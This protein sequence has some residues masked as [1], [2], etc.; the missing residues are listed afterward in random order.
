MAQT[1]IYTVAWA[2]S[3]MLPH[4]GSPAGGVVGGCSVVGDHWGA[5]LVEVTWQPA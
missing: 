3:C 1:M 4:R 2:L 5:L